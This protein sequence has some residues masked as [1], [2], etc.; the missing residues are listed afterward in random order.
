[1]Y[2]GHSLRDH[3][4]VKGV[5]KTSTRINAVTRLSS[6]FLLEGGRVMGEKYHIGVWFTPSSSALELYRGVFSRNSSSI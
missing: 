5:A 1:M 6:L 4:L 2:Q 3:R